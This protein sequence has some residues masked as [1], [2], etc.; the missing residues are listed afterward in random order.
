[1]RPAPAALS[2]ARRWVYR[3]DL[4]PTPD[5]GLDEGAN[6]AKRCVDQFQQ[7]HPAGASEILTAGCVQHGLGLRRTREQSLSPVVLTSTFF[8][9]SR[10]SRN[11][12][13]PGAAGT[14][15]R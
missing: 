4:V 7:V 5:N 1:M 3:W 2:C 15:T 11:P 6:Y 12:N 9:A 13:E 10:A 14:S 8:L